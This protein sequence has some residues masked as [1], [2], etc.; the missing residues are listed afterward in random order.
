MVIVV[1]IIS[2]VVGVLHFIVSVIW[3]WNFCFRILVFWGSGCTCDNC[4][5]QLW[6]QER[7]NKW[8]STSSPKFSLCCMMGKV[9]L[10]PTRKPPNILA[11]LFKKQHLC[12]NNFLKH[13]RQYN[14]MFSFTSM[15]GKIDHAINNGGGPY[16]FRLNG[17]N[18]HMI[19]SLLP[20]DG[21][22]S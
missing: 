13:I 21:E 7:V 4:S 6:P 1:I 16:V 2:Y 18:M 15:G 14:N 8:R 9:V 20:L 12:S 22:I 11:K 3:F 19:R 10:P 5:A 17:E